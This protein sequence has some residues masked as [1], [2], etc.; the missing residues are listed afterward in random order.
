MTL[1]RRLKQLDIFKIIP[2]SFKEASV[3]G[4]CFSFI[5]ILLTMV[6]LINELVFFVQPTISSEMMIDHM[7]DD[8]DLT[9]NLEVEFPRYPC[10]ML[11][12]DKMDVLHS[13]IMNVQEKL[14]K[15]RIKPGTDFQETQVT[16]EGL[17]FNEKFTM[18]K[19][20]VENKEGCYVHG[21]FTIK[22]V[23]GN[24]HISFHAYGA[25]F[26][27]L[28][29]K[30]IYIPDMS[31][32]VKH[33]SFGD[34]ESDKQAEIMSDFRLKTLHTLNNNK[35]ENLKEKLGFPHGVIN[36][37]RIIPS[38][39]EYDEDEQTYELYQYTANS[40]NMISR[41]VAV[42]FKFEIE[43]FIMSFRRSENSFSHF[44]IQCMSILGGFYTLMLISKM[45]IEDGVMGAVFKR[46]IGK[47]E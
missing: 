2:E 5:F 12:L 3:T 31:H 38:R 30:Q 29:A 44:L 32:H 28:L 45:F 10:A 40:K 19:E 34:V 26:Q 35:H 36:E 27:N 8:K 6:L 17:G 46:R 37:I 21:S 41:Q 13:H 14:V 23:P 7:K 25:E 18:I 33:L 15:T 16:T 9:V 11:S 1:E 39:F 20:Q 42:Y 4:I 24:F 47:L 22:M 43:N